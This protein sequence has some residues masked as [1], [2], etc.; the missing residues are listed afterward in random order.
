MRYF[1]A[2]IAWIPYEEGGRKKRPPKGT[3]YC[4]LISIYRNGNCEMWS[5][6]FICP[7]FD[8]T[9]TIEFNFLVNDAPSDL[10]R[11][12]VF[13]DVFEGNRKVAKIFVLNNGLQ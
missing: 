8:E 13:Y 11:N 4:P 9:K 10:V 2:N 7:D 12:N 3:R 5:I 6:D 1:I